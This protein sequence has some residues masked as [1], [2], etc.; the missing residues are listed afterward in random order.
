MWARKCLP[1]LWPSRIK[2]T[3]TGVLMVLFINAFVGYLRNADVTYLDLSNPSHP[4][5]RCGH[6]PEDCANRTHNE[7]WA[8]SRKVDPK[9]DA[10]LHCAVSPATRGIIQAIQ[11]WEI[12]PIHFGTYL[13][14]TCNAPSQELQTCK[15]KSVPL[16]S[17]TGVLSR[18]QTVNRQMNPFQWWS[19]HFSALMYLLAVSVLIHDLALIQAEC[20][21]RILSLQGASEEMPCSFGFVKCIMGWGG[22]RQARTRCR[23]LFFCLLPFW[24]LYQAITFVACVYCF[25]MLLMKPCSSVC[26]CSC[27]QPVRLSRVMVFAS[28]TLCFVWIVIFAVSNMYYHHTDRYALLW[29][30]DNADL[31]ASWEVNK[32][33]CYCEFPMS[34]EAQRRVLL[35]SLTVMLGCLGLALRSLKGLR[36]PQWASLFSNQY[37]IPIEAWPTRWTSMHDDDPL[38]P[39]NEEPIRFR[40]TGDDVQGEPAFDPFALMDEQ[41]TSARLLLKL[42]PEWRSEEKMQEWAE[43]RGHPNEHDDETEVGCC[44][45]PVLAQQESVPKLALKATKEQIE[46]VKKSVV[47][48]TEDI[49]QRTHNVA[50]ELVA[51]KNRV[52]KLADELGAAVRKK[53]IGDRHFF[54]GGRGSLNSTFRSS[55]AT[56]DSGDRSA[57]P[58]RTTSIFIGETASIESHNTTNSREVD[59]QTAAATADALEKK[60][61]EIRKSIRESIRRS[62]GS[63]AL[64]LLEISSSD[65]SLTAMTPQQSEK[66]RHSGS[67]A[68]AMTQQSSDRHPASG[69]E[70][71]HISSASGAPQIR[72]Y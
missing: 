31:T 30:A 43:L 72:Q 42:R 5:I 29:T 38:N 18:L 13:D 25:L 19:W 10:L 41:A 49:E 3:I 33:V 52:T 36:H 14:D 66:H 44:G 69:T 27:D 65:A 39:Y 40:G 46:A 20:R 22:M 24:V 23:P 35:L 2:V 16:E 32:C 61:F 28:S 26:R 51:Q 34:Q 70:M 8:R 47:H 62:N 56:V 55:V 1:P 15:N 68:Q 63:D 64:D 11:H 57:P 9:V 7:I 4:H 71:T 53:T 37:A 54:D 45:F 67:K 6:P 17:I 48:I 50:H 58:M 59:I 12:S 21:P 60:A